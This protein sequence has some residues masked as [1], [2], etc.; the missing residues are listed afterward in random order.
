MPQVVGGDLGAQGY[1]HLR[2]VFDGLALDQARLVQHLAAHNQKRV[3]GVATVP[4][5]DDTKAMRSVVHDVA[6][7]HA[8]EYALG[9]LEPSSPLVVL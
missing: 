6:M 9:G 4:I 1:L 8:R 5:N 3:D 2:G 7:K